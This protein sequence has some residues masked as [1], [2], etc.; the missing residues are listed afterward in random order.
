MNGTATQR[1]RY[2]V[3]L[4]HWQTWKARHWELFYLALNPAKRVFCG[5]RAV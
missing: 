5:V 3:P 2:E 4:L 1:G